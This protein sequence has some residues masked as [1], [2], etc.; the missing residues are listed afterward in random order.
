MSFKTTT[1][2]TH[3]LITALLCAGLMATPSSASEIDQK[4]KDL[5]ELQQRIAHLKQIIDV[6][7]DSKSRYIKQL[8]DIERD[9]GKISREIRTTSSKIER[10]NAELK[11][12]RRTRQGFQQKLSLENERLSQ[13]VYAAYTLGKQERIKFLFSQQDA[14]VLQR[15]IV[16]YRYFS[17]ARVDLI[18]QVQINIDNILETENKITRTRQSLENNRQLLKDQKISLDKDSNKRKTII[19]SLDQ[20]LKKQGGYLGKLEDDAGE[21]QN[22]I[23]SIEEILVAIPEP[24]LEKKPF[25]SLRGKLAWPVQGDVNKLF[26]RSKPLSNLRWQGVMIDAPSGSH[27]KAISSGR[28]A[29]AD[30][31][32]GLGNLI[33]IDHGNS[34]L[35]LYGHNESLFKSAG[36]WVESGDIISSI[37]SSGGLQKPSLYFE[38]RRGGKPQNPTLW[39]KKG[40]AFSS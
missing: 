20:Q 7:Q 32:R 30:W 4:Q 11:T 28:I 33:I 13:Q 12:F 29:F 18:D 31:L 27:V 10:N 15:N 3:S 34:Y 8:K 14:N 24:L 9:I 35:S 23:R 22:L 17:N 21:L 16:Y 25:A 26:A 40:N 1:I 36:E 19:S 37:G 2:I 5:L 39:C 38:I 6:K